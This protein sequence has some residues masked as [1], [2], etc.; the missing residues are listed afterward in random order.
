VRATL[1]SIDEAAGAAVVRRDALGARG[2]AAGYP[3]LR[4]ALP[5]ADFGPALAATG[6]GAGALVVDDTQADARTAA[7]DARLL[8]RCG[9]RAFATALL[10][11]DGRTLAAL[12]VADDRPRAW[13]PREVAMVREVAERLWPAYEAARARAEAE[14]AREAA[15]RANAAKSQF[16]ATMSHELRTPLNAI[17]ATCS[18]SSSGSTGR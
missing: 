15:E 6:V 10:V 7:A 13:T 8:R 18:S 14:A 1:F 9:T 5:L 4:G 2:R 12:G 16:L 3:D 11:R 17:S